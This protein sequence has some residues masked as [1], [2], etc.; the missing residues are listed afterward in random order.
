[1]SSLSYNSIGSEGAKALANAMA[2]SK[3]LQ[4][5]KLY[6]KRCHTAKEY[7][8][9][10]REA[11]VHPVVDIPEEILV[12]GADKLRLYLD[13]L[14]NGVSAISELKVLMVGPQAVGKTSLA[15]AL[16]QKGKNAK[17]TGEGNERATISVDIRQLKFDAGEG[18]GTGKIS[19][20]DFGGQ[21]EYY[22]THSLFIS[23]RS[24]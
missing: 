20:W 8:L 6:D 18:G 3:S 4:E 1:M 17:L 15:N 21:Q 14:V 22:M 16:T 5:L 10:C 13:E 24:L 2:Q 9:A 12:Q 7:S 11:G 19:L 23:S